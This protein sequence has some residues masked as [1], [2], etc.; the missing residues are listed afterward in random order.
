MTGADW[1]LNPTTWKMPWS[2]TVEAPAAPADSLVLRGDQ[3][4]PDKAV[5]GSTAATEL[6]GAK[7]LYRRGEYAKAEGI[8]HTIA[9]NTK[10]SAQIA[11]E[12]R[13]YEADCL[14]LQSHYPKAADTYKKCLDDFP[15]GLK[16]DEANK[17]MFDIANYWLDAT[18]QQMEAAQEKKDGKRWLVMPA[19]FVHFER[20]KPLLDM[21]GRALDL[22]EYVHINDPVGPLGEKALFYL[23][24]VKFFREDYKEADHYFSQIVNTRPNSELAKKAIELAIIAKQMSTGGPEYDGRKCEEARQLIDTALRCYPEVA[25]KKTEFLERQ[26]W[27]INQQEADKDFRVAEF[28]RRTGHPGAAYFYYELVR[29]RYPGSQ[30]A[31]DATARMDEVRAHADTTPG[32][33]Q[34]GPLSSFTPAIP[35][36]M[37]PGSAEAAPMPRP[38]DQAPSPSPGGPRPAEQAPSP[39][40]AG[41]RT[42]E[43]A[44]A[45]RPVLGGIDGGG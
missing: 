29:R 8:F 10:N 24:S 1:S 42:P 35:Q 43:T 23:G 3:L 9:N 12:A 19:S 45:P 14:R 31:K 34:A 32:P 44:P 5:T 26:I 4:E 36:W 22:L 11:E 27:S 13:Y 17:R 21:E 7:E 38:A 30:Y 6:A 16:H 37:R 40:P 2:K 39:G 20:E 15:S 41:S 25:A 33:A 18:R 28:Y